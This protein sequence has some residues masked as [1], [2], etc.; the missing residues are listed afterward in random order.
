[1]ENKIAQEL[2]FCLVTSSI[3]DLSITKIARH[4]TAL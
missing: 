4:L 2:N 1:M 3:Y